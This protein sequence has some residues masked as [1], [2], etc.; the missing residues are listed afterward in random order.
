MKAKVVIENWETTIVLD[1]ENEFEIDVLE[2]VYSKKERYNLN[3]IVDA[4]YNYGTF[5]KHRIE[6]SIKEIKK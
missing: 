4:Q 6:I 5:S 2:K 3:T 1:T